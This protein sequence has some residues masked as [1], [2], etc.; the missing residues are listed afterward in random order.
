SFLIGTLLFPILMAGFAVVPAVIMS[1]KG[2][3]TRIVIVDPTGK[4]APRIKENLSEEK[5]DAK[6]EQAA[7]DSLKD[8]NATQEEKMKRGAE[9]MAHGF[10][11]VEYS[12]DAKSLEQI[13]RELLDKVAENE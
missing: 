4:I 10:N 1:L 13:R 3:P 2:E 6:A 7:R 8:L 12:A 9:Q 11:F 5:I